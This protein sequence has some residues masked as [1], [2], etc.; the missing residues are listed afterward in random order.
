MNRSRKEE[1]AES[2]LPPAPPPTKGRIVLYH[3]N[4]TETRP[5]IVTGVHSPTCVNVQVF[6]DGPGDAAMDYCKGQR[7]QQV[8]FLS[9]RMEGKS[10]GC[11]SW[12]P[13]A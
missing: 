4:A 2:T 5:A 7:N 13:R 10:E 6:T 11:W 3:I 1:A 12:P 9:S 8:V